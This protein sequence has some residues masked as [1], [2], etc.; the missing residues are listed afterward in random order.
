LRVRI[1]AVGVISVPDVAG[2][3]PEG[4]VFR[5]EVDKPA[6][7]VRA[8]GRND[9]VVAFYPASTGSREKPA[10][11]GTYHVRRVVKEPTYRYDPKFGFKGPRTD[12][13]VTIE[14]CRASLDRADQA[15]LLHGTGPSRRDRQNPG[16]MSCIRLT[17]WDA[18]DFA[19][20]VRK[21]TPVAFLDQTQTVSSQ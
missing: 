7:A 19:K 18:L 13:E 10:P 20:R 12:R 5:I 15:N 1:D 3:R 16:R 11:S 14:P 6:R 9:E 21:G 4:R 8:F 17:N 2:G